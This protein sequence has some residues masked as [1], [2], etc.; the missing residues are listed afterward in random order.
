MTYTLEQFINEAIQLELNAAE[1]YSL[2]SEAI[3]EDADFWAGL[4][5]EE[6]N[7]ASLLKT[8]KDI[9]LPVEQFPRE[10]LPNFIQSLIDANRW[11]Q[12]LKNEYAGEL[13]DRHAAFAVAVKIETSA[14]EAHFQK[15]M[16]N[17]SGS[18]VLKIFQDLCQD[19]IHHL[20]RIK[21]YMAKIGVM[22]ELPEAATKKILLAVDDDSVAKLLKTIL[23][24]EGDIDI[25]RNGREGLQALKEKNY[26]LIISSVEMPLLD[27]LQFFSQGKNIYPELSNRFLFFTGAA[28]PERISFFEKEHIKYLVKPSKISEIRATALGMLM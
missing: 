11:L 28:T 13:P 27:G 7:H 18:R 1:I 8:G 21:E 10:I 24:T 9:L 19:D 25:V 3:P 15:V 5:W 17:T 12:S 2:F 20:R 16:E 23:E 4:S 22:D 26:D 14:G 6:R